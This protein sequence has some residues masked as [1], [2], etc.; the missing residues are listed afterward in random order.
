MYTKPGDWGEMT[1]RTVYKKPL[2]IE[3]LLGLVSGRFELHSDTNSR[4]YKLYFF[5]SQNFHD[6]LLVLQIFLLMVKKSHNL[7]L[8]IISSPA[9]YFAG[10]GQNVLSPKDQIRS[11]A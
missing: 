6:M 8:K 1:A 9:G 4:L 10:T 7:D 3:Q 2:H 11:Y 5:C